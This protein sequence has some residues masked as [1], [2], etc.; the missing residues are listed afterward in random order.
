MACI[1]NFHATALYQG[2]IDP[3]E[4]AGNSCTGHTE[5]KLLTVNYADFIPSHRHSLISPV[6]II[7][8]GLL[9]TMPVLK[10][11]LL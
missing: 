8:I 10:V 2:H 5:G 4:R 6:G 3:R 7:R 11:V 9:F 1:T